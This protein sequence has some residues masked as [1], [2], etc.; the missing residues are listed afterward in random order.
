MNAHGHSLAPGQG[1]RMMDANA[2]HQ[3]VVHSNFIRRIIIAA[4]LDAIHAQV[5]RARLVG[6][7][8]SGQGAR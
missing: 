6:G 1:A 2:A 7:P 8:R 3:L 4:K 5:E